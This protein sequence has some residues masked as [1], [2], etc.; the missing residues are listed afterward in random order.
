[1]SI[2][3]S[4]RSPLHVNT[5]IAAIAITPSDTVDFDRPING[6]Y[7]GG[8]GDAVV[9]FENDEYVTL[10]GLLAGQIYPMKLKRI[11][12][13]GTTATNLVGLYW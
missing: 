11:N 3:T 4:S 1:M 6:F 9:V 13:T 7:V 10:K 5:A 2:V 12:A 8:A